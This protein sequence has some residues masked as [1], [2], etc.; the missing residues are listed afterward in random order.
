MPATY[1]IDKQREL[2]LSSVSGVL[3]FA[4]ITERTDRLRSD[5]DFVPEYR[6]LFDFTGVTRI[7]LSC[8]QIQDLAKWSPFAPSSRRA[9]LVAGDLAFGL[10]RVSTTYHDLNG[11]KNVIVFRDKDAALRWLETGEQT[12]Q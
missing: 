5:P 10:G 1:T 7:E 9:F 6:E 3:T 12:E 8:T 2:V 11:E 4:G